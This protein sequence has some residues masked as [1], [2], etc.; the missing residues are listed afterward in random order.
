MIKKGPQEQEEYTENEKNC[1]IFSSLHDFWYFLAYFSFIIT[2]LFLTGVDFPPFHFQD[3]M[4]MLIISDVM[5]VEEKEGKQL[6]K[7]AR[8][9]S[10]EKERKEMERNSKKYTASFGKRRKEERK[11]EGV[12]KTS[13]GFLEMKKLKVLQQQESAVIRV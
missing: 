13:Y 10:S 12:V 1:V 2:F 5:R 6:K 3:K 9:S 7:K 11:E 8:E 4:M